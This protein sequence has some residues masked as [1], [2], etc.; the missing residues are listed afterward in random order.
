VVNRPLVSVL[1]TAYN[2]KNYIREAIDSVLNQSYPYL[3]LIIVDDQSSDGTVKIIEEYV[4]CDCR[5]HLYVNENNLGDYANRNR[6]ITYSK[7][8]Y[9]MFVDSDDSIA[10]DSIAYILEAFQKYPNAKHSAIY[11]LSDFHK[12]F[13][14]TSEVAINNHLNGMNIL[15]G[16][17][18]S[19]FF[20][21]DFLISIGLYPEQYGPSNDM[22][23]N[24]KSTAAEPILFLPYS[25]LFYREHEQ[26]ENKNIKGYL[27]NNYL[28]FFDA[29]T[30]LDL[31]LSD[32]KKRSLLA[33]NKKRFIV[34]L[35]KYFFTS[36]DLRGVIK[37]WLRID[38]SIL[39]IREAVCS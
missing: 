20:K 4:S 9:I 31:P 39:D 6:A 35:L 25:Y 19:R 28:Y 30:E 22:Y 12:P 34:N 24:L 2:R 21:R 23:F 17:P 38:F 26:Q 10:H 13:L 11:Y 32:E 37:I 29:L 15:A 33:K 3:E 8:A 7:G 1:M 5:V 36:F 16:G 18:G 27:L 14:C